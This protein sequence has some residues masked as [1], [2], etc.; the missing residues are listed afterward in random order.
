LTPARPLAGL[1]QPSVYVYTILHFEK[2]FGKQKNIPINYWDI[3]K[4]FFN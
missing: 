2:D 1:W 3:L 4:S